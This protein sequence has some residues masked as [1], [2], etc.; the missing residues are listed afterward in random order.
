MT[1]IG[2]FYDD[3]MRLVVKHY[4]EMRSEMGDAIFIGLKRNT[5]VFMSAVITK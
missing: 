1:L 2:N 3:T 4:Q 5:Q